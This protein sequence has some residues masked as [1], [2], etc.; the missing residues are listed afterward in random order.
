[1]TT[2]KQSPAEI[3]QTLGLSLQCSPP[4]GR[5]D[6]DN[7]PHIAY[8]VTLTR[9]GKA[10]W[11][12]PYKLGIGNVQPFKAHDAKNRTLAM[13]CRFSS[14]EESMCNMWAM[15]PHAN[16]V[17]KALQ[18]SVAAKLALVQKVTPKLEDVIHS[19]LMDGSAHFDSQTFED[20]CGCLGYDTD[21][22]KAES[23]F[24]ECEAIGKAIAR[25]FSRDELDSLRE[26]FQ[27][28]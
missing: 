23:T 9:N 27:D 13:R 17:N 18:A 7:W 28:Y 10:V 4:S 8:A 22:R 21:S 24:R 3:C 5:V 14:D 25:A 16:F 19:L 15:K 11:T 12:G 2:A 1:M 6:G 26:A 20:W